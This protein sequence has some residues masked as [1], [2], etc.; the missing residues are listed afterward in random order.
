VLTA[1]VGSVP[2]RISLD[3]KSLNVSLAENMLT[4]DNK[5]DLKSADIPAV[6]G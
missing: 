4:H 5:N 1:F 6:A 2:N 3:D